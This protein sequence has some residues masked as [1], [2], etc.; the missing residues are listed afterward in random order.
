MTDEKTREG[1]SDAPTTSKG[2]RTFTFKRSF[3]FGRPPPDDPNVTVVPGPASTF[4]WEWGGRENE[5]PTDVS[6]FKPAT[7]YEALSGRRDPMRNFFINARRV[8]NAVFWIIAIGLPVGL[9]TLGIVTGQ[10]LETVVFMGIF[11]AI[12]G[13]MLRTTFP[14]TPFG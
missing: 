12:I 7:Y 2:G 10:S 6:D 11:G 8:I 13:L 1:D 3:T 5:S 9:V 14:R 4:K